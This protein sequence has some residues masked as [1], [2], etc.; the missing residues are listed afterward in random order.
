MEDKK[1]A[2]MKKHGVG[3]APTPPKVDPEVAALLRARVKVTGLVGRPELNGC[4]G[5]AASFVKD[6]GRFKVIIDDTEEQVL[7]KPNNLIKIEV[8]EIEAEVEEIEAS[9]PVEDDP[10]PLE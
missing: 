6:K 5:V 9:T 2:L 1:V 8:E 10:P 7:L 4:A 3:N